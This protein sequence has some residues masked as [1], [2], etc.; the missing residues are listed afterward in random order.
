MSHDGEVLGTF[1]MYYREVRHPGPGEIHLIDYASRIAALAIERDRSQTAVTTAFD[2][3]KQ[4]KLNSD[5]V[6]RAHVMQKMRARSLADL[7]KMSEKIKATARTSTSLGAQEEDMVTDADKKGIAQQFL[8]I[9]RNR[10]WSLLRSIMTKDIVWSLPG[11]SL[12]SGEASGVDAVIARAQRIVS[13]GLTFTL[14]HIL[15]G[16]HGLALSLHNTAKNG[17]ADSRRVSYDGLCS[18]EWKEM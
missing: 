9:L 14:K 13:Y 1:G 10:D 8:A 16:Q 3:I 2:K 5:K 17:T 6:H 15:I 7:V 11:T 18:P 4:S 12:I